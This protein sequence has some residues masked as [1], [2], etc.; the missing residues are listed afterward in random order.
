MGAVSKG[1][2]DSLKKDVGWKLRRARVER[3]K[4][5]WAQASIRLCVRSLEAWPA[6]FSAF[7]LAP[8]LLV[9]DCYEYFKKN[10]HHY[11]GARCAGGRGVA[12][13]R[14]VRLANQRQ[15]RQIQQRRGKSFCGAA[16]IQ[17]ARRRI[18]IREQRGNR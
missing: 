8:R 12:G 16:T 3:K 10:S 14:M 11:R 7:P 15:N 13:S 18:S 9:L 17:G 1:L 2:A 5:P 6:V 4:S